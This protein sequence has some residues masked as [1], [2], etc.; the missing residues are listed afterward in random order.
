LILEYEKK[1]NFLQLENDKLNYVIIN[2]CRNMI[3]NY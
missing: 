2:R 3:E 1:L